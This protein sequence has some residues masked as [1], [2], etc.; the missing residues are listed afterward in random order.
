MKTPSRIKEKEALPSQIK[1]EN[2]LQID[3]QAK[4]VGKDVSKAGQGNVPANILAQKIKKRKKDEELSLWEIACADVQ[5]GAY[6][7]MLQEDGSDSGNDDDDYS[8]TDISTA[9][10]QDVD[11]KPLPSAA[12][13]GSAFAK[14]LKPDAAVIATCMEM[15]ESD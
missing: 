5:S 8:V 9:K 11:G 6:N 3:G 2:G 7:A 13:S 4:D 14:R 12:S 1:S 10:T 15:D